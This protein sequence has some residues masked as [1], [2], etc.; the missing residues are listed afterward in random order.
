[1][2]FLALFKVSYKTD[3]RD[4]RYVL[5]RLLRC[6]VVA[7]RCHCNQPERTNATVKQK[8]RICRAEKSPW[9]HKIKNICIYIHCVAVSTC[10]WI[11]LITLKAA[12]RIERRRHQ[13]EHTVSHERSINEGDVVLC[14]QLLRYPLRRVGREKPTSSRNLIDGRLARLRRGKFAR[15][16]KS[17]LIFDN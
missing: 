7:V 8:R 16:R 13:C 14:V 2:C 10:K 4:K 11:V 17:S 15:S 9:R 1:M 6:R 3:S 12:T 5:S